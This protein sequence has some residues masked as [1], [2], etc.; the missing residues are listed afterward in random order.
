MPKRSAPE[1][2]RALAPRLVDVTNDVLF[3]DIWER[4]GLSARDQPQEALWKT[5]NPRGTPFFSSSVAP[6]VAGR[7]WAA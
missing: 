4:P 7:L 1:E 5:C 3:G 6:P 2:L